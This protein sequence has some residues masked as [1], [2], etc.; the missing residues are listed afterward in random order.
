MFTGQRFGIPQARHAGEVVAQ[1]RG[2]AGDQGH[3]SHLQAAGQR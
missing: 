2:D 1:R 3:E